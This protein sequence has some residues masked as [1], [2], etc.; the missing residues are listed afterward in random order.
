MLETPSY[1]FSVIIPTYNR[2]EDLERCLNSLVGQT[3]KNFEVLV[4]DNAS[5]DQTEDLVK[6]YT[7]TLNLRYILLPENSG[8]P[9]KPRNTGIANSRGEWLC[10]LDSDDWYSEDKLAY[11]ANLDLNNL[12]FI[13][14]SLYII[15]KNKIT[16]NIKSRNLSKKDAYHDLLYNLNAVPTSSTC[17][18]KSCFE[19]ATGFKEDKEIIGLED[20]DLWIRIA[21]TGARF[22]YISTVL[23][24]YVF[25]DDNLTYHDERQINR[26]R[27]LYKTFIE[28]EENNNNKNKIIAASDYLVGSIYVKNK[29][30]SNGYPLLVNAFVKGSIAIKLRAINMIL[31]AVKTRLSKK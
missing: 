31:F 19:K 14:H 17:I 6:K 21:K 28:L 3:F 25:G 20:F 5:T 9:A 27:A 7:D 12:D 30:W 18:R 29:D 15:K 24:S 23:G 2:R 16:G 22:K 26:F 11:V 13:Y 10:F 1:L 4:C 8:G